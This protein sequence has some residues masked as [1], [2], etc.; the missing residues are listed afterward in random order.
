LFFF[1]S[2]SFLGILFLCRHPSDSVVAAA[3]VWFVSLDTTPI[4]VY[5]S[6]TIRFPFGFPEL[7]GKS[8]TSNRGASLSIVP[9]LAIQ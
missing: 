7:G 4:S 1:S 6:S 8:A 9:L 2:S 5:T 3:A